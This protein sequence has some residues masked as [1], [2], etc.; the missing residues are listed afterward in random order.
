MAATLVE[1]N[2]EDATEIQFRDI[3]TTEEDINTYSM[4]FGNQANI[5]EPFF[6]TDDVMAEFLGETSSTI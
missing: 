2:A 6:Y 1:R 3:T 4:F 5:T